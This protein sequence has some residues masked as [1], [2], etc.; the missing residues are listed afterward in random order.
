MNQLS[1]KNMYHFVNLADIKH[2]DESEFNSKIDE[3]NQH[4]QKYADEACLHTGPHKHSGG[5]LPA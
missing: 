2:K 3:L 5:Y 1:T 4:F